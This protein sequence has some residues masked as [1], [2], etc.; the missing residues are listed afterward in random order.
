MDDIV[1]RAARDDDGPAIAALM[2][3]VF[4]EYEGCVVDP[5]VDMPDLDGVATAVREAGG[6][7]WVAER[8]GLVV[9]C[10]GCK[11]ADG[12]GDA[13]QLKRLYVSAAA[14]RQ[15]LGARLVGLVEAEAA[16][17]TCRAIELWS[18]TRFLDAHRLYGRL[19][20]VRQPE[21]RE[22]HDLSN[23]V[24]YRFVKGLA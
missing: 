10:I 19:G 9:A 4:A 1:I 24:E 11:P 13:L 12:R 17:R 8:A 21:T 3:A 22:L 5:D 16:A 15:G 23:T 6:C 18:D 20:Y 2:E 14:R 7:C